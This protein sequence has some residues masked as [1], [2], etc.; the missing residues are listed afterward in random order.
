MNTPSGPR[1]EQLYIG[2]YVDNLLILASHT[3]EH[4]LYALFTRDLAARWDVEDEG[5]VADLLSVEISQEDE[6]VVL[7]QVNY[8]KK[9]MRTYAPE[10]VPV[11]SFSEGATLKS[12]PSG[13]VLADSELP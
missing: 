5:E 2:C 12:Q 7:R 8:I 4:S 10:G 3:D 11:S 13:R 1:E 9:M 6:H